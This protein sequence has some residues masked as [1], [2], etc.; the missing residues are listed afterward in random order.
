MST[1]RAAL[2]VFLA[3]GMA[4]CVSANWSEPED[5][6]AY[7][8]GTEPV[9]RT[10]AVCH[11]YSCRQRTQMAFSEEDLTRVRTLLGA[12]ETAAEERA[13]LA[14]AIGLIEEV[15]GQ[16]I[17]TS[18]DR[19]LL[20]TAGSGDP[21]QLDCIDETANTTSYLLVMENEGL[22]RHHRVRKPALR[23]ML[24]DGRWPHFT[25]VVTERET[26]EDFAVDSWVR[27]NGQPPVVMPLEK[28]LTQWR[29]GV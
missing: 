14:R 27:D 8:G 12:A 15:V 17:G 29:A 25:A 1:L 13:A 24:I 2:A 28:W 7:I 5:F 26:G 19:G 22:F 20:Y 4:G 11:S 3:T 18:E 10:V 21:G 23:G 9:G 16:S 6:Y